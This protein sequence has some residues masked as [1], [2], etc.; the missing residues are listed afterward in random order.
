MYTFNYYCFGHKLA[1]NKKLNNLLHDYDVEF[2]K[3]INGRSWEID[4]PYHGG[5]IS[6]DI[7]YC[8]FGT[9]ITDDDCN[10][11]YVDEVRNSKE[12]DYIEDY[13]KFIEVLLTELQKD[14][15]ASKD[16][17]PEFEKIFNMLKEF[18]SKNDPKFY[19]VEAS[20]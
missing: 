10:P 8:I 18:L 1:E 9:I 3:Y 19:S 12:Q 2:T 4:F 20:S 7:Y 16:S 14:V 17:E 15:E 6:G 5:Q 13:Y 11:N